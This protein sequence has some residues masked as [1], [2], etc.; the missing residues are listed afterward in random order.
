MMIVL[1]ASYELE[2]SA[3]NTTHQ[4]SVKGIRGQRIFDCSGFTK[5]RFSAFCGKGA[6]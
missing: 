2:N 6:G 1:N 5:K 3:D 4:L